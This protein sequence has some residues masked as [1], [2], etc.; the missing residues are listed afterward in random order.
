MT[1]RFIRAV[2]CRPPLAFALNCLLAGL[3][4][5]S[6][7]GG[8]LAKFI[9]I[10]VLVVP[11]LVAGSSQFRLTYLFMSIVFSILPILG[12]GKGPI[13]FTN[14]ESFN[15]AFKWMNEVEA[16][17]FSVASSRVCRI[18]YVIGAIPLQFVVAADPHNEVVEQTILHKSAEAKPG[19]FLIFWLLTGVLPAFVTWCAL[20]L[21]G[22]YRSL[23]PVREKAIPK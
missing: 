4:S 18:P 9:A 7:A 5:V 13:T 22:R 8:A 1:D 23:R 20:F 16:N 2:F 12:G 15:A 19:A 11:V 14:M 6:I 21:Y 10:G 17:A 3:V